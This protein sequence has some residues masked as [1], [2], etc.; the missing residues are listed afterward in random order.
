MKLIEIRY[1]R[2]TGASFPHVQNLGIRV[3]LEKI[4]L[5]QKNRSSY[6]CLR[7]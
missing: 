1:P 4:T 7:K 3:R 2:E 6:V 5:S